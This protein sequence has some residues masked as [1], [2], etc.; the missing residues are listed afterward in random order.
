MFTSKSRKSFA[1]ILSIAM[2]ASA[3]TGCA[4]SSKRPPSPTAK[5]P[6]QL[7]VK[8]GQL[9]PLETATDPATGK[10]T[11]N[12]EQVLPWA[13]QVLDIAGGWRAQLV[14]LIEAVRANEAK[15]DKKKRGK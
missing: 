10:V 2:C 6:E 14:G 7:L 5:V 8:P 3:V 15:P 1:A 11:A 9:P 13:V 12:G 4:S